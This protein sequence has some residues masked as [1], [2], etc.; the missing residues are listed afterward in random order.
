[1]VEEAAAADGTDPKISFEDTARDIARRWKTLPP[2]DL[3]RYKALAAADT[4]RYHREMEEYQR[5]LARKA[6][7]ERE[8]MATAASAAAAA[9][10]PA[11]PAGTA[12]S[13]PGMQLM[14]NH[15]A[16][17]PNL[18]NDLLTPL[19]SLLLSSGELMSNPQAVMQLIAV[20]SPAPPPPAHIQTHPDLSNVPPGE[21]LAEI[22]AR[23]P[24]QQPQVQMQQLAH[25]QVYQ[26]P[27]PAPAPPAPA[28]APVVPDASQWLLQQL[29]GQDS[30]TILLL[31]QLLQQQSPQQ[32]QPGGERN[33]DDRHTKPA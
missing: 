8:R 19:V 4:D 28:P 33:G 25:P 22:L 6:R 15:S 9:R 24:Q 3:E 27:Q 31:Q 30:S 11:E 21:L 14:Q 29:I 18:S 32:Q 23:L 2:E 7:V 10:P 26:P 5:E 20:L 13:Q 1:M 17:V 16:A 12:V